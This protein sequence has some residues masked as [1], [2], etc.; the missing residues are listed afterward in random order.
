M[1]YWS[2][3]GLIMKKSLLLALIV[4][5]NVSSSMAYYI[6]SEETEEDKSFFGDSAGLHTSLNSLTY[7]EKNSISL[8]KSYRYLS[9]ISGKCVESKGGIVEKCGLSIPVILGFYAGFLMTCV[10]LGAWPLGQSYNVQRIGYVGPR[11]LVGSIALIY[12]GV[13]LMTRRHLKMRK[14]YNEEK[15]LAEKKAQ[16]I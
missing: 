8:C 16:A 2:L 7:M 11:L 12:S 3:M 9:P 5:L 15:K 13:G 1:F 4:L 6:E 10:R 14:K